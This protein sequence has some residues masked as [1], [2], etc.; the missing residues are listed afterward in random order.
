MI[1]Y[2]LS[3]PGK[4]LSTTAV[5]NASHFP[6]TDDTSRPVLF[7]TA[8]MREELPSVP[9]RIGREVSV[10]LAKE[11]E[12]AFVIDGDV[13]VTFS[14]SEAKVDAASCTPGHS[15]EERK[16]G[17]ASP[18]ETMENKLVEEFDPVL[19]ESKETQVVWPMA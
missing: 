18:L 11:V 6:S 3:N 12:V 8:A 5:M 2:A 15:S 10:P 19:V 14:T 7:T 4:G 17:A 1:T 16:I 9:I 13:P